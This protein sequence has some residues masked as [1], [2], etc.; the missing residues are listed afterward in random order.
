[1]QKMLVVYFMNIVWL[2]EKGCLATL[3]QFIKKRQNT[4]NMCGRKIRIW[5]K[6]SYLRLGQIEMVIID[7]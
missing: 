1:M 2:R 3:E 4:A 6:I 7:S 5:Y